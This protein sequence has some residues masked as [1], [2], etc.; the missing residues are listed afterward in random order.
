MYKIPKEA[1]LDG[2]RGAKVLGVTYATKAIDV[3][4]DEE[5]LIHIEGPFCYSIGSDIYDCAK[6]SPVKEYGLLGLIEKK[7]REIKVGNSLE[8]ITITFADSSKL[9]LFGDKDKESY[10]IQYGKIDILV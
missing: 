5:G 4:F 1:N 3:H 6:I 7:V 10:S 2:M 9:T 8:D